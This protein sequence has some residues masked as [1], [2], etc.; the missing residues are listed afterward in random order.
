MEMKSF[1]HAGGLALLALALLAAPAARADYAWIEADGP[2][3]RVQVGELGTPREARLVDARALAASGQKLALP[4]EGA[5]WEIPAAPAGD[6]RFSAR[7]VDA[8]GTLEYLHARSG[9]HDTRAVNDLELAPTR[10]GGSTFRL[11]WKGEPVSASL[12]RVSTAVGWQK[13]LRPAEDGSVSLDTPFPGLYVLVVSAR[14]DGGAEV[15]GRRYAEVRHTASLS[16][17]VGE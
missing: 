4:A 7:T 5:R 6:L 10:P 2:G 16:F 9:R 15:D 11:Y 8:A 12:V 1:K 13:T 14:M 3:A 17:R